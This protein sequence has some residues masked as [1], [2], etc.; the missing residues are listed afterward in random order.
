[1]RINA[2]VTFDPIFQELDTILEHPSVADIIEDQTDSLYS[3]PLQNINVISGKLYTTS[4]EAGQ[5]LTI[6]N[7]LFSLDGKNEV[8]YGL[9]IMSN[10]LTPT[11]R[12]IEAFKTQMTSGSR[13]FLIKKQD[14]TTVVQHYINEYNSLVGSTDRK[15]TAKLK[16]LYCEPTET[17]TEDQISEGVYSTLNY[18]DT[19]FSSIGAST[20]DD[21]DINSY[22]NGT[23]EADTALKARVYIVP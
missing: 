2:F 3:F 6:T 7:N 4:I 17:L 21:F 16:R 9:R 8:N 13:L 15:S 23:T 22:L 10:R 19:Y 18:I 1:M 5:L 14:M 12:L 20:N 11:S